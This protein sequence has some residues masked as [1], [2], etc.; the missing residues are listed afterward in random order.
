[1]REYY[2]ESRYGNFQT[3]NMGYEP[4]RIQIYAP[5]A[6]LWMVAYLAGMI[7]HWDGRLNAEKSQAW[8][9]LKIWTSWEEEV[10]GYFFLGGG[11]C[12]EW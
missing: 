2:S 1:M 10:S 8:V 11:Q 7:S 12:S 4:D 3:N 9:D 5:Q 6:R